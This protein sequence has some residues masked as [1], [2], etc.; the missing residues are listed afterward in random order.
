MQNTSSDVATLKKQC[1][2]RIA[3]LK[4]L[5]QAHA[6]LNCEPTDIKPRSDSKKIIWVTFLQ[7]FEPK[8]KNFDTPTTKELISAFA[9]Y[10]A[11]IELSI[12]KERAKISKSFAQLSL[13]R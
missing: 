13:K 8:A 12:A 11:R 2:K 5:N 4:K 3:V 7:I 6:L 9:M 1:R 10:L